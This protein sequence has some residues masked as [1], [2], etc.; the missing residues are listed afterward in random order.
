M[1]FGQANRSIRQVTDENGPCWSESCRHVHVTILSEKLRRS[2]GVWLVLVCRK[3]DELIKGMI[4][5]VN[6]C[7]GGDF[8]KHANEFPHAVTWRCTCTCTCACMQY[9]YELF[10]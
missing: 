8:W 9:I 6:C 7:Q 2:D 5:E 10:V 4:Y 3:G 1:I